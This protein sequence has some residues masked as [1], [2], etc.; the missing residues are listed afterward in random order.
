MTFLPCL[1]SSM[2]GETYTPGIIPPTSTTFYPPNTGAATLPFG[3]SSDEPLPQPNQSVYGHVIDIPNSEPLVLDPGVVGILGIKISDLMDVVHAATAFNHCYG[4]TNTTIVNFL[5]HTLP[6]TV[7]NLEELKTLPE[8][9][10]REFQLIRA[11][12]SQRGILVPRP[13]ACIITLGTIRG[14]LKDVNDGKTF[15]EGEPGVVIRLLSFCLAVTAYLPS[16][17]HT[18]NTTFMESEETNV[19]EEDDDQW[20]DN[21]SSGRPSSFNKKEI[22]RRV[23]LRP[24][25]T[26][27]RSLLTILMQEGDCER[28]QGSIPNSPLAVDS[29]EED[30]GQLMRVRVTRPKPFIIPTTSN[31]HPLVLSPR[32]TR[33]NMLRTELTGSLHKNL[34]REREEKNSTV[35]A[36]NKRHQSPAM[37]AIHK[38]YFNL[39]F[40]EYHQKGW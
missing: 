16:K 6:W 20:E 13:E 11:F 10:R 12:G 4:G 21:S 34:L 8:S 1:F 39:G 25:L 19:I 29:L 33:Q 2:D 35:N 37:P 5:Y 14:L 17:G 40:Q 38:A 28:S 27:N 3:P 9:K 22:F 32:S 26:S 7:R 23:D 30:I 24:T 18:K 15:F 31:V 36:V